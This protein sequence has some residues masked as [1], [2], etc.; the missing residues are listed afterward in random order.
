[1]PTV[2][3]EVYFDSAYSENPLV[4]MYY[5]PVIT[6]IFMGPFTLSHWYWPTSIEWILLILMGTCIQIAQYFLTLAYQ[7]GDPGK[8]GPVYYVEIILSTSWGFLFFK[9]MIS[10]SQVIGISIILFA[11]FLNKPIKEK[12]ED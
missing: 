5:F 1:M 7:V 8:I 3:G 6:L 11:L 10:F 4:I 12:L 2:G 9:E